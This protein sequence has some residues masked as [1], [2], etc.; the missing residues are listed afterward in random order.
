[1]GRSSRILND[2][3]EPVH[4]MMDRVTSKTY[5]VYVEFMTL[6]DAVNA[7]NRHEDSV[8]RGRQPRLGYRH[9]DVKLSSQGD[10]MKQLFPFAK[11]VNWHQ[12]PPGVQL[13]SRWSW[14][15]FDGFVS[16]E[17]MNMM[18]KHVE[19]PGRVSSLMYPF[20]PLSIYV[21]FC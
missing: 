19:N 1:M 12:V 8:L 15:N 20:S 11:G 4:I 3:D 17:E 5:D 21:S 13:N 2:V 18:W 14:E 9:V 16:E 7:V 10:L 6:Q